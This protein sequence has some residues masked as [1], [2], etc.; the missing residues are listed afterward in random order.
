MF[1]KKKAKSP[2]DFWRE[3]E[4]KTGET[5]LARGL[6]QYVSGWEPFDHENRHPLWGLV[7]ATTGGF[8]FHHFPQVNWF[9]A[10]TRLNSG[11]EAPREKT[12]FIP[13]EQIM[14]AEL[15]S[16]TKWWKKILCPSAPRLIIRY[17]NEAGEARELLL[18]TDLKSGEVAE[19]LAGFREKA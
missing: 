11:A 17:Q 13:G 4:E 1:L 14:S 9:D 7:I 2:D 3:Y 12:I 10:I 18:E 8:R 5:V 15:R 19:R 16:E 6:G